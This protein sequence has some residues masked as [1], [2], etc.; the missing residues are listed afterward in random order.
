M[1]A[2]V[3]TGVFGLV[4]IPTTIVLAHVLSPAD[5][6][7]AAAATFFGQFAARLSNGGMGSALVR[8]KD[9]RD[10]HVSSVFVVNAVLGLLGTVA[11]IVA[12]PWIADFYGT[13]EVGSVLPI[14]AINFALGSLSMV[15]HALL[16]RDLRYRDMATVGSLDVTVSAIA[17]VVLA[18]LGFRYWSLV[19]GDVCGAFAK[20]VYGIRL[21][22]WHVRL[23]FVPAAARELSSFAAGSYVR[24]VLEH[25]TRNVDN[26]VIGRLLGITALGFYDKAFSA[27]NRVF[28]KMTVVGPSVSFRIFAIIQDEPDR[29]RR[30]YRKVIMTATLL[31]YI[32]FGA[33]GTMAPHLIV[34]AFGGKWQPSVVPFQILCMAFA[35]KLLNSYANAAAQARGWVWSQVWRQIVE[36]ACIVTGIYLAADWGING[37]AAAILA[38]TLAMFAL[39]QTM[40]RAATGLVWA[41]VLEPQIPALASA[42]LLIAMLWGIDAVLATRETANFVVLIAQAAAAALFALAFAWWCPFRDARLLMHDVVSDLSPRLAGWVWKDVATVSKGKRAAS[43]GTIA[44]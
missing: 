24:R 43:S 28:E 35:L 19:I 2:Y 16:S 36:I 11:L 13:P 34:V 20:W 26:M 6:G 41:D 32:V 21:V 1:W 44:L 38:A 14:V 39:T 30:A 15:Q 10:D 42:A 23:R 22:G 17:A 40:M 8:I 27:I 25:F 4:G 18:S 37:A 7:I 33:L 31:G 12:A 5:F 3:R 29:F 9:L